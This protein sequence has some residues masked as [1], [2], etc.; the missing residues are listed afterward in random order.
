MTK[1]QTSLEVPA[2][3]YARLSSLAT[4]ENIAV[5]TLLERMVSEHRPARPVPNGNGAT[6]LGEAV[7]HEEIHVW[8]RAQDDAYMVYVGD[9]AD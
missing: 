9:Y 5:P 7:A 4:A 3:L 8:D 2:D 6:I 1:S